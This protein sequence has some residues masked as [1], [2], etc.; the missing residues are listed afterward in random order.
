MTGG[1]LSL[2]DLTRRQVEAARRGDW[3]EVGRL[4]TE[5][6]T[7]SDVPD[8]DFLADYVPLH[9]ELR[10]LLTLRVFELQRRLE[11]IDDLTRRRRPPSP[12]ALDSRA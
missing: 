12:V 8:P 5:R 1:W 10:E 7:L 11:A 3:S 2:L 4:M 6:P 9:A